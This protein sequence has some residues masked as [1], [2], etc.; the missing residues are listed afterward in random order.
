VPI[1][2]ALVLGCA[3]TVTSTSPSLSSSGRP[4]RFAAPAGG[5]EAPVQAEDGG[6]SSSPPRVALGGVPNV[7][8]TFRYRGSAVHAKSWMSV[9]AKW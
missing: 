1:D 4:A 9:S 8:A 5:I 2:Q 3:S 6:P 7:R